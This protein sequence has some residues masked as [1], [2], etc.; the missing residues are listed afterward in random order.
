[1]NVY[2]YLLLVPYI[3]HFLVPKFKQKNKIEAILCTAILVLF[4]GMRDVSV[5]HDT[6]RY[7]SMFRQ[8]GQSG[9]RPLLNIIAEQRAPLFGVFMWICA[10]LNF[11][12]PMYFTAVALVHFIP[13]GILIYKRSSSIPFSYTMYICLFLTLQLSGIKNTLATG[14]MFL[15]IDAALDK[16]LKKFIILTM[17][18]SLFHVTS[19]IILLVYPLVNM[20]KIMS[21]K[22]FPLFILVFVIGFFGR[23]QISAFFKMIGGYEDYGVLD[24]APWS[25]TILCIGCVVLGALFDNKE[26][27]HSQLLIISMI[28]ASFMPLVFVNPSALRV[29]RYFMITN[30]LLVPKA[31]ATA[32]RMSN[33]DRKMWVIV[34]GV[35]LLFLVIIG[36][37]FLGS[38][39]NAEVYRYSFFSQ[40]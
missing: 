25:M 34:K 10:Q 12:I 30:T 28:A 20:K 4:V 35:E 11:S 21:A 2:M 32:E 9:L 38:I 3:V 36:Y 27:L 13:L 19:L 24:A 26:K 40:Y 23:T 22:K 33:G 29:V 6:I 15:C 5:G 8:A 18:A 37:Q 31:F 39:A 1:M 16:K 17:V 7:V 14:I